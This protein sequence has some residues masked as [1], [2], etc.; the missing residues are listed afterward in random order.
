[1]EIWIKLMNLGAVWGCHQRAD[2]SFFI[3]GYQFPVCA[4]CTGVL[5][6]YIFAIPIFIMMRSSWTCCILLCAPMLIDWG[7]QYRKIREAT[8]P[9][10]LLTGILGGIGIMSFQ[11]KIVLELFNYWR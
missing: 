4:R 1:M 5:M 8:Q 2:R 7:L 11:I 10:R 9:S 3:R 6:G